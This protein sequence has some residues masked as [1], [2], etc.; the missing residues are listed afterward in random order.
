M[1]QLVCVCVCVCVHATKMRLETKKEENMD[2]D[3]Q[4]STLGE[5]RGSPRMAAVCHT[6]WVPEGRVPQAGQKAPGE[7]LSR[8]S[9]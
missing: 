2:Y 9:K 8:G 7:T 1:A 5:P 4:E 3:K 6:G